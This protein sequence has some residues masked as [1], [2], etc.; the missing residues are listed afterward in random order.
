MKGPAEAGPVCP[1]LRFALPALLAA[2][3]SRRHRVFEEILVLRQ[4]TAR[5]VQNLKAV[6][7]A[8]GPELHVGWVAVAVPAGNHPSHPVSD[9]VHGSIDARRP[10]PR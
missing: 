7:I 8:D 4:E 5:E 3:V 2:E 10:A 1:D 9:L 6:A